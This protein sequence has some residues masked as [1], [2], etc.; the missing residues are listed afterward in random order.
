MEGMNG[1]VIFRRQMFAKKPARPL[2][3]KGRGA[4]G[5]AGEAEGQCCCCVPVLVQHS[6]SGAEPLC[7][8]SCG[9]D[10]RFGQCLGAE[11]DEK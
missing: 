6:S 1:Q 7:E 2:L 5:V 11:G 9:A 3:S 10:P 8:R 4:A